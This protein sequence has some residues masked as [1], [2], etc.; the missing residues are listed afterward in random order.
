M[1]HG[2]YLLVCL[3]KAPKYK[4]CKIRNQFTIIYSLFRSCHQEQTEGTIFQHCY[5]Q[6]QLENSANHQKPIDQDQSH[7]RT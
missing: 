2:S 7:L 6:A 5:L 1:L 3:Q 4:M